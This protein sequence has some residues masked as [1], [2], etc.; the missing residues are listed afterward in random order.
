MLYETGLGKKEKDGLLLVLLII[1]LGLQEV[2]TLTV[3]SGLVLQSKLGEVADDVLHLGIVVGTAL[4]TD[5]GKRG[6]GVEEVVDNGD[7]DSHTNGVA[8]DDNDGD[9]VGVAVEGLGELRHGVVEGDLV[10][11][12]GEPTEDTEQSGESIDSADGEDKLPRGEG[13]TTAGDEDKPV[14]SKSDLEEEDL[15]DV[16]PVLDDTTV[17]HVHGGADNP[18]SDGKQ[19]TE[20]SGDDPDLGKLPLNGTLLGVSVVV[21]NSDSGQISE[22]SDEDNQLRANG[23]VDD[24]HGGDKVDLQVQAEGNTVLDVSL[25]ALENLACLLDGKDDGGKTRGKEDDIGGSLGSLGGTLDG[26]TTVRL[27]ERGSIVDTV[28]SHGGQVTTLLEHLDD[29]VLVLGED[30]G[31]TVSTLDE[32]VL[33]G[34]GKTTVDKLVRVV[35]LG[36]KSK[37]L[38]S[39]LSDGKSVTSKHLDGNTKLLGLDNS[40]GS[41]LTGRVEHREHTEENPG[42]VVLL[43]SDTERAETTTSELSS[44]VTEEVGSLLG[45]GGQVKDSLGGTLS[46]S[47]TRVQMVVI[48]LETGSKGVNFSVFQSSLRMSRAL[49]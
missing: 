32:I 9:D 25:H 6:D 31:E 36:T 46:A 29:L 14:L 47:E 41:V 26:N 13:L 8:P 12:A 30:L 1:S 42:V 10:R 16:T 45:A 20:D 40:L 27:L 44:L 24:D 35:N 23:L 37:H 7:D 22:E 15:L 49:G 18:G 11:V 3:G 43:V 19:D 4:A 38:A 48:R 2:T 34:T 28:T 21:G 33:S 5:V 17:G 39:L